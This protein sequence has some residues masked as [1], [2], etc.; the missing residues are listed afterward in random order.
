MNSGMCRHVPCNYPQ[1][2]CDGACIRDYLQQREL[3]H[4]ARRTR[5]S[6]T[7]AAICFAGVLAI[8]VAGVMAALLVQLLRVLNLI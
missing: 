5:D 3:Q 2:E 8:A 6:L 7:A 1:G 4:Q